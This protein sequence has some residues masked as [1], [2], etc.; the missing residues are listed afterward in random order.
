MLSVV[1]A[2]ARVKITHPATGKRIERVLEKNS[3]K[4]NAASHDNASWCTDT[5]GIL[6]HSPSGGG[7]SYRGP[8]LQKVIPFGGSP[9]SIIYI[10]IYNIRHRNIIRNSSALQKMSF[11]RSVNDSTLWAV[12]T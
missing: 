7:L 4:P 5:D 8:A 3:L 1:W 12:G 10:N 2:G 9:I 6:E 11:D